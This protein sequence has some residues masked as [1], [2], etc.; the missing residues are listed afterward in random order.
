MRRS[1]LAFLTVALLCLTGMLEPRPCHAG[2]AGDRRLA[3]V[4]RWAKNAPG[5]NPQLLKAL[6]DKDTR[7]SKLAQW[8]LSRQGDR[9]VPFLA[10]ALARLK[11]D[12]GFGCYVS[13]GKATA[14]PKDLMQSISG[15][16]WLALVNTCSLEKF[17]KTIERLLN[18]KSKLVRHTAFYAMLKVKRKGAIDADTRSSFIVKMLDDPAVKIKLMAFDQ[19]ARLMERDGKYLKLYEKHLAAVRGDARLALMKGFSRYVRKTGNYEKVLGLLLSYAQSPSEDLRDSVQKYLFSFYDPART[20]ANDRCLLSLRKGF[21]ISFQKKDISALTVFCALH[22][23]MRNQP[24][25]SEEFNALEGAIRKA[26]PSDAK[27]IP[28]FLGNFLHQPVEPAVRER[29]FN[30]LLACVSQKKDDSLAVLTARELLRHIK[31]GKPKRDPPRQGHPGTL[32][33]PDRWKEKVKEA[34]VLRF[35]GW[36]APNDWSIPMWINVYNLNI[37]YLGPKKAAAFLVEFQKYMMKLPDY[38]ST[39]SLEVKYYDCIAYAMKHYGDDPRVWDVYFEF[40]KCDRVGARDHAAVGAAHYIEK[41]DSGRKNK[42]IN[43]F[44]KAFTDEEE[45]PR[46]RACIMQVSRMCGGYAADKLMP[47]AYKVCN[48]GAEPNLWGKGLLYMARF[49][50]HCKKVTRGHIIRQAEAV[51]AQQELPWWT[52]ENAVGA[53]NRLRLPGKESF[54]QM[55]T[56][57]EKIPPPSRM[58]EYAATTSKIIWGYHPVADPR[59]Y[60]YK[61]LKEKSGRDF[62]DDIKAWRRWY[63]ETYK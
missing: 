58:G 55:I 11:Q 38:R 22:H 30:L 16:L 50:Q 19:L 40:L 2:S 62:G 15:T 37:E 23:F 27:R 26:K 5:T 43:Y 44:L 10:D 51:F 12:Y 63:E 35:D 61:S 60:V 18:H 54:N 36:I 9:V 46:F 42:I 28:Q 3:R 7:V 4:K 57:L 31:S 29:A 14:G 39:S 45:D 13:G 21:K 24:L 53:Y 41:Q 56:W 17:P 1:V 59:S 49:R 32:A 8:A 48:P 52:Y 34:V 47:L 25:D 33:F 6:R 20:R